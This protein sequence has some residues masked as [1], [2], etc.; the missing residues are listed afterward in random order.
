MSIT[1]AIGKDVESIYVEELGAVLS[2]KEIFEILVIDPM[3]GAIDVDWRDFF[4]YLKW[5]PN[6]GF[7]KRIQQM[8]S[9]RE[10]V[11]KALIKE[12]M[13]RIASGEVLSL[14]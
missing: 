3:E 4:P 5:I 12:H 9:H 14:P 6:K 8:Y 10:A 11:M 13:K 1:Q 7:E 2:R